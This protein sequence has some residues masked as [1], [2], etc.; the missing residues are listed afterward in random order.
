[1]SEALPRLDTGRV[2][3][4]CLQ[5]LTL[6]IAVDCKVICG[7]NGAAD[8]PPADEYDVKGFEDKLKVLDLKWSGN[9]TVLRA[10]SEPQGLPMLQ[11]LQTVN[12]NLPEDVVVSE[13]PEI[14][15][16]LIRSD[17]LTLDSYTSRIKMSKSVS[18]TSGDDSTYTSPMPGP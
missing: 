7:T 16:T 4:P 17:M 12:I 5:R 2:C 10:W 9:D 8:N 11:N 13:A 6:Q 3:E 15:S 18:T 14:R 1:M